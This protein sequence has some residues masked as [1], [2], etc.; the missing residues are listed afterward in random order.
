MRQNKRTPTQIVS[1]REKTREVLE[2][3]KKAYTREA[4]A[5][6]RSGGGHNNEALDTYTSIKT[7]KKQ[8][9]NLDAELKNSLIWGRAQNARFAATTWPIINVTIAAP[10]FA[11]F[12]KRAPKAIKKPFALTVKET[13]KPAATIGGD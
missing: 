5:I 13:T 4:A 9:E 7:Y 1:D 12:A 6:L 2:T 10:T 11:T 8:L 3:A